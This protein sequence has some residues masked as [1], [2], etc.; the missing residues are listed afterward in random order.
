MKPIRNW[1]WIAAMAL[2]GGAAE[3]VAQRGAAKH[4]V[5]PPTG[6]TFTPGST[7]LTIGWTA[8]TGAAKYAVLR[9]QGTVQQQLAE[10]TTTSYSGPLPQQ[11]VAYEYQVVSI[12]KIAQAPSAWIAYT[13]PAAVTAV[14][15]P[16]PSGTITP[17]P[18]TA[19]AGPSQFSAYSPGPASIRLTWSPVAGASGYLIRKMVV[20]VG[21][22][23]LVRG[24]I[25]TTPENGVISF[26]E[27]PVNYNTLYS[28]RVFALIP[29]G[30]GTI[31]SGPSPI[32]TAQSLPFVQVSGL[33]WTARP[34]TT[35]L[36]RLDATL[37]W[38]PLQN[39]QSYLLTNSGGGIEGETVS[40]SFVFKNFIPNQTNWTVCV[41]ARYA[42]NVTQTNTAPCVV[43][44]L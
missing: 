6:I 23:T 15:M 37:T 5:A 8:G 27:V 1:S 29:S 4:D 25:P 14:L 31:E 42:Y 38:S 44:K 17:M 22:E 3:A 35:V 24:T 20:G 7:T 21:N 28:Y 34:S 39:V 40:T 36:G 12:G 16:P 32:A 18:A 11:G 43:I 41:G 33:T 2:L 19:I 26:V 13:V 10:V 30:S 9:R